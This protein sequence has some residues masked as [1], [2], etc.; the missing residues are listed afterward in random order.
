MCCDER[1]YQLIG[2]VAPPL[3]AEP[4]TAERP[5]APERVDYEYE[6][7]GT[8]NLFMFTEPLAGWRHVTVTERRTRSDFA[9]QL[10]WLVD[11]RYPE[12]RKIKLVCDNLNTHNGASLYERFEPA[13]A[14]RILNKI[15]FI[16]TPKHGSWLNIA[17]CELSALS[18]QCLDRRMDNAALVVEE[19]TAWEE[20]RNTTQ[21]GVDWQFTTADSRIKLKRLYPKIQN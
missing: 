17:E 18:R 8:V 20:S 4:A 16:Y 21:T 12:A 9:D 1:S 5:G 11:E 19:T 3:V 7:K 6:R 10:R 15:E 13:E 14:R 2:E